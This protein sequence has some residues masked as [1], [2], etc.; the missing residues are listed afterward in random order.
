MERKGFA[1]VTQHFASGSHHQTFWQESEAIASNCEWQT[2]LGSRGK[3]M[4][5]KVI[6]TVMS[7]PKSRVQ[8]FDF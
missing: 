3:P 5:R 6:Y 2:A 8:H 7:I 1:H 4:F